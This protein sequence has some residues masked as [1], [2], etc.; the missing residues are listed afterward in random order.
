MSK[1]T[2]LIFSSKIRFIQKEHLEAFFQKWYRFF[3]EQERTLRN[4]SMSGIL[5]GNIF[6]DRKKPFLLG[7]F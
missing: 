5:L 1:Y 6:S 3:L 4:L 7:E 2:A